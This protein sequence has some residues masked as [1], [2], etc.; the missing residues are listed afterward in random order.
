[1]TN[2]LTIPRKITESKSQREALAL[3]AYCALLLHEVH[4][5]ETL[6]PPLPNAPKFRS[7]KLPQLKTNGTY[8]PST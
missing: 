2:T 8:L 4:P 3:R 1:M 5:E 6:G 7:P